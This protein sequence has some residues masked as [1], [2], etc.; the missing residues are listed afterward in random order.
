MTTQ[1]Y[2]KPLLPNSYDLAVADAANGK[3]GYAVKFD[4]NEKI[5]LCGAGEAG[6]GI[7]VEVESTRVTVEHVGIAKGK[8]GAAI[9]AAGT[10][11]MSDGNGKLIPATATNYVVAVALSEGVDLDLIPV[12]V[13]PGTKHS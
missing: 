3:E 1:S 6:I 9:T 4:A 13:T 2:A 5:V 12:L 7:I 10:R 8:A 11:L